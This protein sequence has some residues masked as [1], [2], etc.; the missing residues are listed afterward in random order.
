MP[1]F[2]TTYNILKRPDEDELYHTSQFER[3]TVWLPPQVEWDY[4]REMQI[5][6]VDIWEIILEA[7]EGF[8]IYAAWTPYAEFYLI[9]TGFDMVNEQRIVEG[10]PYTDKVWETYYGPGASQKVIKRA[11]ELKLPVA[12]NQYWVDDEQMWLHQE[13][14]KSNKLIILPFN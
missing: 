7:S 6:D 4:S 14:Q 2:K 12:V 3:D 13:E 5:E 10:R 8:G 11:K 1:Q 9:T